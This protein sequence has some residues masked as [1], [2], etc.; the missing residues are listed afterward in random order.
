MR[1]MCCL[2]MALNSNHDVHV[3]FEYG[4]KLKS[5]GSCFVCRGGGSREARSNMEETDGERLP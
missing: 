2:N 3:M 5:L 1:F 4:F